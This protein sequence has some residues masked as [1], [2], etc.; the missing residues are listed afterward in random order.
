VTETFEIQVKL[1][2]CRLRREPRRRWQAK[3][4]TAGYLGIRTLFRV[5][6]C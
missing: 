4:D 2:A 3:L 6:L 5:W 1:Q